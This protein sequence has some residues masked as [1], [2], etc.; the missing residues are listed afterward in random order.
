M[1]DIICD[2]CGQPARFDV[3]G[4]N[5]ENCG[6]DLCAD[7]AKWES[8]AVG[9]WCEKCRNECIEEYDMQN[10]NF[11]M[12]DNLMRLFDKWNP[13]ALRRQIAGND[14]AF[15]ELH[16]RYQMRCRENYELKKHIET[17]EKEIGQMRSDIAVVIGRLKEIAKEEEPELPL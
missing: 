14:R 1:K 4:G 6:D 15:S 3:Q 7:C 17:Q 13:F 16:D 10:W 8:D 9:T 11:N 5:C 2:R 12:I